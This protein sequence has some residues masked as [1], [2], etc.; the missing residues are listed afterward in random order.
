MREYTLIRS[1]RKSLAIY[2][3][4][5]IVEARAPFKYPKVE[6]DKFVASKESWIAGKLALAQERMEQK[7]SF[8]LNYGDELL[9]RGAG[10]PIAAKPVSQAGF[11]NGRFYIPP[12]LETAQIKAVCINL[13]RHLATIH[14]TDRTL[15]YAKQM[16]LAPAA[17]KINNAKT[18]WGSC[19]S[20]GSINF[21]W[22]LI[23]A[24]DSVIDYVVVHELAH[25]M[26]MNHSPKF[27]T[28]VADVMPDYK[29][30][31]VQLKE[32]QNKL[33]TEDWS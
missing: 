23:M 31:Q 2:I 11:E 22:R 19:S 32:L 30:R 20:K 7:E 5:G 24:D 9:Y 14:V 15:K 26:E 28:I 3:R 33:A 16:N 17:I 21:S 18:R 8:V 13:Y 1:K 6:I 27:W 10:Y 25:L 29:R 12:N 4:N